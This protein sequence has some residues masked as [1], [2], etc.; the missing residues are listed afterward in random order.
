MPFEWLTLQYP[1]PAWKEGE[2]PTLIVLE[3]YLR[4]VVRV[5]K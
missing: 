5:K 3:V 1:P 2:V 4:R